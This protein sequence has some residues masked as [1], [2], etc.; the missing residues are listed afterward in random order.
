MNYYIN[1]SQ[2]LDRP[3]QNLYSSRNARVLNLSDINETD[4]FNRPVQFISAKFKEM[5][6]QDI[7]T[8]RELGTKNVANFKAGKILIQTNKMPSFSNI[9][10]AIR[11]RMV[12][13]EFR[14]TFTNNFDLI[15]SEPL[16]YKL[17]DIEL[18]EKLNREEYRIVF[19]DILF[20]YHKLFKI[21]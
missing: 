10:D 14:F 17:K 5:Q 15:N 19:T 2:G 1:Y 20:E 16:K 4:A 3:N 21:K 11:G 8:H 18:N 6:G 12:I 13:Q 9:N 7:S